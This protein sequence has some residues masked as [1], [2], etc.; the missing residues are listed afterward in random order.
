MSEK[1]EKSNGGIFISYIKLQQVDTSKVDTKL[2][3]N[4]RMKKRKDCL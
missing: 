3:A 2:E 4:L 1:V